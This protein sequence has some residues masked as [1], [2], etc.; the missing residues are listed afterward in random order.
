MPEFEAGE[1]EVPSEAH[2]QA[3]LNGSVRQARHDVAKGTLLG[4]VA[5]G[6][7]QPLR[8]NR[9]RLTNATHPRK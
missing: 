3:S 2:V 9:T 4:A 6:V 1:R 7:S 8:S 5:M